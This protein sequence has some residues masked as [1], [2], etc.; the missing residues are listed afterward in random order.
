MA[1]ER[2]IT[3]VPSPRETESVLAPNPINTQLGLNSVDNLSHLPISDVFKIPLG[4]IPVND[5]LDEARQAE[6]AQEAKANA[7]FMPQGL[8]VLGK[9]PSITDKLKFESR[10]PA[11]LLKKHKIELP[12]EPGPFKTQKPVRFSVADTGFDR[13]YEHPKFAAIGFTPYRSDLED[14]YNA[15]SS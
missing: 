5:F 10:N 8:N 3:S 13:Y 2:N 12:G 11:A 1:E 9:Q 4:D 14:V 7:F 6:F 15:N